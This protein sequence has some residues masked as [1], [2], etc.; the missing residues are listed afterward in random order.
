MESIR[1]NFQYSVKPVY[2][3]EKDSSRTDTLSVFTVEILRKGAYL[4]GLSRKGVK[5]ELIDRCVSML[6]DFDQPH[7]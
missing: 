1:H 6:N 7:N 5:T 2:T 4:N 3:P